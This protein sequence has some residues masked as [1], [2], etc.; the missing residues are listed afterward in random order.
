MIKIGVFL[1]NQVDQSPWIETTVATL[2]RKGDEFEMEKGRI[3]KV[4][5]VRFIPQKAGDSTI[6]VWLFNPADGTVQES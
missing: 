4:D 6:Q 5:A 3:Y 1:N 2:P